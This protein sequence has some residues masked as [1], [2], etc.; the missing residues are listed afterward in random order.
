MDSE[1][2]NC[3]MYDGTIHEQCYTELTRSNNSEKLV[4]KH[5]MMRRYETCELYK[6]TQ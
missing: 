1:N 6:Q 4:K 5:A 3:L 2:S